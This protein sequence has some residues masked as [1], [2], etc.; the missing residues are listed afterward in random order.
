MEHRAYFDIPNDRRKHISGSSRK[1]LKSLIYE[2]QNAQEISISMFLYN[3]P[4]LQVELEKLAKKGCFITIYSLPLEGYDRRAIS[5]IYYK[6]FHESI[7]H[8]SK[9]QYASKVYERVLNTE[10]MNLKIFPHTYIWTEQRTSRGKNLFS[11]HSK[12]LLAKF[13]GNVTKSITASSNFAFGDPRHSENMLIVENCGNTTKMFE[14]YFELLHANSLPWADYQQKITEDRLFDIKYVV[15]PMNLEALDSP[16]YFT[17]PFIKYN[18][19]GSNRFVLQK[20]IT[21]LN[22]AED[23]IYIC[24]QHFNNISPYDGY[25]LSIVDQVRGISQINHDIEIK[26]LKQTRPVDQAQGW[27]TEETENHLM[28]FKNVQQKYWKNIIHDKFIIVDDKVMVSTAN[29]TSTTFAWAEDYPM[30]YR[31]QQKPR[32][33]VT[34]NNTFSEVNSFHFLNDPSVTSL[35]EDHFRELWDRSEYI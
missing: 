22:Q 25:H 14:T 27:R 5:E 31:V 32:E 4:I 13:P 23:R 34:T 21:L 3:N 7:C 8:S 9:Y 20:I 12:C 19:V 30:R 17:G 18:G 26:I 11:L 33:V 28:G 35:Y 6:N 1:I 29:Y 24:S 10:N 15:K 2:L 16:C